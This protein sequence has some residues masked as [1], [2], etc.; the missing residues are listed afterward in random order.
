M[1]NAEQRESQFVCASSP[2]PL[3]FLLLKLWF[4]T[5]DS[6]PY[7]FHLIYISSTAPT[8]ELVLWVVGFIII[9]LVT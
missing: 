5:R 8:T 6:G 3:L 1:N 7:Y 2:L 4:L 9:W